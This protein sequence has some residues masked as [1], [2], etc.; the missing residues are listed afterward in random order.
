ME[1]LT[2]DIIVGKPRKITFNELIKNVD[3]LPHRRD[4]LD[5][6]LQ[7][8]F[9]KKI[10]NKQPLLFMPN[11]VSASRFGPFELHIYGILPDGSKTCVKVTDIPIHVDVTDLDMTIDELRQVILDEA[12]KYNGDDRLDVPAPTIIEQFLLH[13]F[14]DAP[15]PWLRYNFK[16]FPSRVKFLRFIDELKVAKKPSNDGGMKTNKYHLET[17]NDDSMARGEQYYIVAA[18]THMFNTGDWNRITDY[19]VCNDTTR[20]DVTIKVSLKNYRAIEPAQLTKISND[21]S[22]AITSKLADIMTKDPVM[23]IQW[24]IETHKSVDD[25]R[26]PECG[27]EYTIFNMCSGFFWHYSAKPLYTASVIIGDCDIDDDISLTIVCDNERELL[28]ANYLLWSRMKPDAMSA[29]NGSHFD[30]PIYREKLRRFNLI[31]E[32][33]DAMLL[34]PD[35]R[36]ITYLKST[37]TSEQKRIEAASTITQN[38]FNWSWSSKEKIKIDAEN[39]HLLKAVFVV[40]GLIDLDILPLMLKSYP[41]AEVPKL[42]SLNFFLEKNK[43]PAKED[44]PYN[45]M[46]KIFERSQDLAKLEVLSNDFKI[47]PCIDCIS[48][49]SKFMSD[50]VYTEYI[51]P[52]LLIDPMGPNKIELPSGP[53]DINAIARLEVPLSNELLANLKGIDAFREQSRHNMRL[54]GKYCTIDC[55]RPQQLFV[56]RGI[57][58]EHREIANLPRTG[59]F[60]A[61]YRAGGM[62]VRNLIRLY[63]KNFNIGFSN[64]RNFKK[65][66]DKNHY[67]GAWVFPPKRGLHTDRPITGEDVSSLYPSLKMTYNFSPD[68]VVKDPVK[69]TELKNRGYTLHHVEFPYEQ[70]EKKGDP[71]NKQLICSGWVVRHNGAYGPN[72]HMRH[73]YEKKI[74]I[75]NNT[76]KVSYEMIPTT[77]AL[78]GERMGIFPY[79]VKMLFDMRVPIKKEFVRLSELL[80]SMH[81]NSLESYAENGITYTIDDL[82]FKIMI[83][84]AKQ[85]AIKLLA[86]TFYG[87][88]GNYL[89]SVYELIV[90]GGITTAGQATIKSADTFCTNSGYT[91]CYGDTDSLYL[92]CPVDIYN[93]VDKIYESE[94]A[95]FSKIT[96]PVVKYKELIKSKL[97]YW[98]AMVKLTMKQMSQLSEQL[99]DHM[100]SFNGTNFINLAYEEVLFPTGLLG[101]KKYFGTP[102]LKEVNFG[103]TETDIDNI[104][105]N[106]VSEGKFNERAFAKIAIET[107]LELFIRGIET[108][109]QGKADIVKT[110]GTDVMKRAVSIWN[111]SSMHQIVESMIHEFYNSDVPA[112]KYSLLGRYKPDKLNVP[113]H[114]FVSRMRQAI[115][116]G[117]DPALYTP[118]EPGDKF[119]YVICKKPLRWTL[120]GKKIEIKKGDQMEFMRVYDA[121]HNPDNKL[122]PLI[123]D[124]DYYMKN[125]I[126]GILARFISYYP[127]YQPEKEYDLDTKDGYTD[128]DKACVNTAS[129]ALEAICDVIT[130][131]NK[132]DNFRT[133]VDYRAIYKSARKHTNE[134][135]LESHGASIAF[136]LSSFDSHENISDYIKN[137]IATIEANAKP[138][139][140]DKVT[141]TT[142]MEYDKLY[143]Q[144]IEDFKKFEKPRLD[145]VYI[146]YSNVKP[147]IS[148]YIEALTRYIESYRIE[149]RGADLDELEFNFHLSDDDIMLINKFYTQWN[150]MINL[151][152]TKEKAKATQ[153]YLYNERR[154]VLPK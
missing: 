27:D 55:V 11:A 67:P 139:K 6:D 3:K 100:L 95:E 87:E 57:Y 22:T 104:I 65:P 89:S 134:L 63:S 105:D 36:I 61:F 39:D 137:N 53:R 102:H 48:V 88:S 23:I 93:E 149:G 129:K 13:G 94:C 84:E 16:D 2:H 82:E 133:G 1:S 127:E 70:G 74:T 115:A 126:V 101:K 128:F 76:R 12:R 20:C 141:A 68:M 107:K 4:F 7:K 14:Q 18:A 86:N 15:R 118:S 121:S 106:L 58:S 59:L 41:R 153:K 17:S 131:T 79:I 136:V 52:E 114:T 56:K 85:K 111:E 96:D 30:W 147:I 66:S 25:G 26:A 90:A 50:V 140:F 83:V 124:R 5:T 78:V 77:N 148:R 103:F 75:T 145:D 97:R 46:F 120:S 92:K 73:R 135:L 98:T 113:I 42:A 151:Y 143:K 19:E 29:F 54:V 21:R 64:G 119:R 146:A 91:T 32:F 43:L 99:S 49:E 72:S 47:R 38:A 34:V 31:P 112:V 10:A 71:Q 80:E 81:K 142:I 28:I 40:P 35:Q 60:E 69:A 150:L 44:M 62:K 9:A 37:Y 125:S 123:I 138:L 45:L 109:K 154:K 24:D 33:L 132:K 130:G 117:L 108:I 122:E 51:K 110:I 116:D 144:R 8:I 152:E